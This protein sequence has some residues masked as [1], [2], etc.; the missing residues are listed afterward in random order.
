M[1]VD[2]CPDFGVWRVYREHGRLNL[3]LVVQVLVVRRL[4]FQVVIKQVAASSEI[5]S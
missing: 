2:H 3:Q 4:C 5:V 1:I